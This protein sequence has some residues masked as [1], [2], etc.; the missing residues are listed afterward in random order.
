MRHTF[1]FYAFTLTNKYTDG[2]I[3][4]SKYDITE[5]G[6]VIRIDE[7]LY[8]E[9]VKYAK[10]GAPEEVCGLVGG[11]GCEILAFYPLENAAHSSV[12]FS[13]NPPEQLAAV[14]DMRS[15]GLKP[16]GIFHSHPRTEAYPSAEDIRSAYDADAVYV[17][18]SPKSKRCFRAFRIINGEVSEETVKKG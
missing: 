2:I 8:N 11:A 1:S 10:N 15:D 12:R 5:G 9:M 16:L 4:V 7:K 6:A 17:I 14:R 18:I 3:I 13:V